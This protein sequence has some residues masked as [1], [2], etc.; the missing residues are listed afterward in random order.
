MSEIVLILCDIVFCILSILLCFN[1][2]TFGFLK[3]RKNEFYHVNDGWV[4]N[5]EHVSIALIRLLFPFVTGLL[6][7]KNN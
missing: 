4:L 7:E 3:N 6:M 5:Y 1:V 2:D